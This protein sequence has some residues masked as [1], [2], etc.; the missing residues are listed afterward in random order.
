MAKP[1]S[2]IS[3]G[4]NLSAV[5]ALLLCASLQADVQKYPVTVANFTD[6]ALDIKLKSAGSCETIK[7]TLE[8]E[9]S[10]NY[11]DR[12]CKLKYLQVGKQTVDALDPEK[13]ALFLIELDESGRGFMITPFVNDSQQRLEWEKM[14]PRAK[15]KLYAKKS[16][17]LK[18]ERDQA[19]AQENER[20]KALEA[21]FDLEGEMAVG[22][23]GGGG[24]MYSGQR[25][26]HGNNKRAIQ[27][28]YNQDMAKLERLKTEN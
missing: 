11:W 27:N 14:L 25:A 15:A 20:Y 6:K 5:I 1:V 23:G 13:G 10:K 16:A 7:A 18:K 17:E 26:A 4:I 9:E 3:F 19:L 2:I 24:T 8:P 28:K 12:D 22:I 21:T